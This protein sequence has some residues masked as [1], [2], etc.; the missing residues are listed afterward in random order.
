MAQVPSTAF[1]RWIDDKFDNIC[2]KIQ[3][4]YITKTDPG[5]RNK[6]GGTTLGIAGCLLHEGEILNKMMGVSEN[7]N[8]F[9]FLLK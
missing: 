7:F 3:K 4:G 8:V 6:K 1:Y 9:K 5:Q 2:S